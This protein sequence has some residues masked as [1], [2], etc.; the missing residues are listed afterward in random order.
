MN[1]LLEVRGVSK[2][3]PRAERAALDKVSFDVEEGELLT[4]VGASGSGKTSLLRILAGLETADEGEVRLGSVLVTRGRAIL[5]PPER[6]HMG[7]VFQNHALFP[8]LKVGENVAFGLGQGPSGRPPRRQRVSDLLDMVGLG[9]LA[10]RYPHELSGGERQRI[11]L[12]RAL[13]PNP[14]LLLMDEPFS[15][16][17]QSLRLKLR[18]ETR[19]LIKR[20][21]ATTILVTHDAEDALA[22]SDRIVVLREGVVQQVGTPAE[23][24]RR[25]ANRYIASSFGPCNFLSRADFADPTR[26]EACRSIE[27]PALSGEECWVRPEDL[28]LSSTDGPQSLTVG[29]VLQSLYHGESRMISLECPSP[30]GSSIELQVRLHGEERATRGDRFHV[31]P[32]GA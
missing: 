27:P 28:G 31:L 8:H 13:A 5:R 3:F 1:T 11:A 10:G 14:R 15:S 12:V 29:V 20:Q 17:D 22:V 30:Q 21:Q 24:Y 9:E 6:R 4:L 7:F 32:A 2:R 23:I 19:R 26:L 16:L 18:D 25:P